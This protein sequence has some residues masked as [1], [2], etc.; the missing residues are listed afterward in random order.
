MRRVIR[1][2][3]LRCRAYLLEAQ[4][5]HA[6]DLI[7]DHTTRYYALIAELSK[8]RRQLALL[9]TPVAVVKD[10]INV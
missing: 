5:E 2:I 4:A 7:D 3:K 1:L 6:A 8:T 10:A 9:R